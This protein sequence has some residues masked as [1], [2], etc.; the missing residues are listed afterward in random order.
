MKESDRLSTVSAALRALGGR[1]EEGEDSLTVWGVEQ[2][3]GGGTVECANDHRVAMMAAVCAAF[4][5]RPTRLV[6]AE[7]VAK[8][9]PDFWQ[10]FQ[11]LGGLA[12][13]EE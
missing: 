1:A 4:A 2:L 11:R 5:R 3:P 12:R 8:S 9:Y 7:C 6:G 10:E 13:P